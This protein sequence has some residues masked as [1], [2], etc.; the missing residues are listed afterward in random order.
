METLVEIRYRNRL[1]RPLDNYPVTYGAPL[2]A[3]RLKTVDG[4]GIRL[5]SGELRPVQAK[6]LESFPDASAKW[7]LLNFSFPAAANETGILELV[8]GAEVQPD[9]E[10]ELITEDSCLRVRTP[11]LEVAISRTQFSF[12]D[13]YQVA[14][15]EM[16]APG[17]DIIVED[18]NGKLFY[19]SLSAESRHGS[20]SHIRESRH[21][22]F[23]FRSH[24]EVIEEGALRTVVEAAGRHTAEDGSELLNF[25]VRYTFRPHEPAVQIAYKFTNVEEPETGV[26]LRRI[27]IIAPTALGPTTRKHL[28]QS[29]QGENW[30]T[31]PLELGEDV[32][33]FSAGAVNQEAKD[34]YGAFAEGKVLIRNFAS[35]RENLDDYP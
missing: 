15:K 35:L 28:R 18:K 25:R 34:R 7:L 32:E 24:I 2:P 1:N 3:G 20:R 23:P 14:G 30:W 27:H 8:A 6:V 12:F 19:A 22:S 33:I 5:P 29:T 31:R 17:S 16:M 10:V 13:S 21:G 11:R 4:L 26:W 9:A